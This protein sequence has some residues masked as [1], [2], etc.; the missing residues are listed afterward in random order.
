MIAWDETLIGE[1]IVMAEGAWPT[2]GLFNRDRPPSWTGTLVGFTEDGRA[3]ANMDPPYRAPAGT[4]FDR[5]LIRLADD[6]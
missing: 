6:P 3:V 5:S 2:G 4:R 1:R